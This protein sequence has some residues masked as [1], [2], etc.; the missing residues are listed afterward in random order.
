MRQ[1]FWLALVVAVV[2]AGAYFG[3]RI[4]HAGRPAFWLIV[5]API[6]AVAIGAA[7]WARKNELLAPWLKPKWGDFTRA[8]VSTGGLFA[9]SYLAAKVLAPLGAQMWILRLYVQVGEEKD[10]Q[11]HALVV[12]IVIFVMAVAEELVWR[13]LVISLL[14]ERVGT[15]TAWIWAAG[16]YAL[17]H[18]PT[19]W[20]LSAPGLNPFVPMAALGCGLV[21]GAMAR[22]TGRL[23]PGILSHALFDWCVIMM[24]PLAKL[25]S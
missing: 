21:W 12:A 5:G 18:V 13:G 17:A 6:V 9:A 15:R 25:S 3:F 20:S 23:A 7:L 11:A 19:M 2:G 1:V 10:L 8:F 22:F 14:E 16:L 24:F 4:E